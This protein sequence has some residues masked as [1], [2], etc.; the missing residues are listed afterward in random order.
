MSAGVLVLLLSVA[1]VIHS[2]VL[3]AQESW[4][5]YYDQALSDIKAKNWVL[6]EER[7]KASLKL[8]PNQGRKVRAYGARFVRYFPEY[9]LGVVAFNTGRYQEALEHFLKVQNAGLITQGDPEYAELNTLSQQAMAKMNP[10]TSPPAPATQTP[11]QQFAS[12]LEQAGKSFASKNYEQA[13]TLANQ[14]LAL[15]VD[16]HKANELLKKIDLADNT[17]RLS[18]AI[19]QS[20]WTDAQKLAAKVEALDPQNPEV[21]RFKQLMSKQ[22]MEQ[23]DQ[24]FNGLIAQAQKELASGNYAK[25]RVFVKQAQSLPGVDL[26]KVSDLMHQIDIAEKLSLLRA[27]VSKKDW[28][29]S[30][31]LVASLE[32]LDSNNPELA[33]LRAMIVPGPAE[34][35][36]TSDD[37]LKLLREA[38][39][40]KDWTEAY[41]LSQKI[42]EQDPDNSDLIRLSP[43]IDAAVAVTA[44][45]SGQYRQSSDLLDRVVANRKDSA[46][47]FFYLGCSYAALAFEQSRA[48]DGLKQKEQLLKK[49]R[50]QF[51]EARKIDPMLEYDHKFI[52]PRILQIYESAQ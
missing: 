2:S 52:S 26:A 39:D 14:A 22:E 27:A 11:E 42:R 35:K 38:V 5:E 32:L 40:K 1:L 9:Y 41:R 47:A 37:S 16:D 19:D 48:G 25:A 21:M 44:F 17:D 6:A 3:F 7:L 33:R 50:D 28:A 31:K 46:K 18:A 49:A 4:W 8:Q 30:Q 12:L 23:E 13:R 10:S 34:E 45:Y 20:N 51:A 43:Q 24:Q 29:Q 15:G 36:V